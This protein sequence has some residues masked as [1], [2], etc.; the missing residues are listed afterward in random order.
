MSTFA[1]YRLRWRLSRCI[2]LPAIRCPLPR[3]SSVAVFRFLLSRE[4]YLMTQK[5]SRESKR[6]AVVKEKLLCSR[7]SSRFKR[8][9]LLFKYPIQISRHTAGT[10]YRRSHCRIVFCRDS[11]HDDFVTGLALEVDLFSERVKETSLSRNMHSRFHMQAQ[12]TCL[13]LRTTYWTHR[14]E[15]FSLFEMYLPSSFGSDAS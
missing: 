6:L 12:D 1:G 13:I 4:T 11:R 15:P 10:I 8:V 7:V 3:P 2:E 14:S 9:S 5:T